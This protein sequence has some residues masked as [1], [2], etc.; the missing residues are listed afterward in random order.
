MFIYVYYLN[1]DNQSNNTFIIYI[2]VH[3]Y[4]ETMYILFYIYYSDLKER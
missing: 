2:Q 1:T 3:V 4:T